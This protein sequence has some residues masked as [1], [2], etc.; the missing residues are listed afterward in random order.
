[1]WWAWRL[2][3]LFWQGGLRLVG[4]YDWKDVSVLFSVAGRWANYLCIYDGGIKCGCDGADGSSDNA[5]ASGEDRQA[6]DI[7]EPFV[8]PIPEGC[9]PL[10]G[11]EEIKAHV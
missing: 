7:Y 5:H 1:M 9:N 11:N 3:K 6:G 10:I 2:F 4:R 8:G